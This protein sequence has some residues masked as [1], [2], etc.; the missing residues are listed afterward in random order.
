MKILHV[1]TLTAHPLL[2]MAGP[3]T[4]H[5]AN[6]LLSGILGVSGSFFPSL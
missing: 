4:H 6:A 5:V 1:A 3:S 2:W